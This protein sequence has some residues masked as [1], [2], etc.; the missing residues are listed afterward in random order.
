VDLVV[1]I[2]AEPGLPAGRKVRELLVVTGDENGRYL[3][4]YV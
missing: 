3:V 1:F 2:D 4:E